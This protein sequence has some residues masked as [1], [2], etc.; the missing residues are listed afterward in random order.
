MTVE[1]LDTPAALHALAPEW[2]ALWRE[3][4]RSAFQSPRWLLPWWDTF[5][6]GAP[7]V[8]VLRE[9]GTLRGLLAAY[10]LPG[11]EP[12]LLPIGAGTTDYLDALGDGAPALLRALLDRAAADGVRACDLTDVPPGSAL[13]GAAPAGWAAVWAEAE[14]CPVL[15][16]GEEPARIRRKLRM[17]RNRADRAGGWTVEA[18]GPEGLDALVALHG[19]R[20]AAEGQAG[21]LADPAVLAFHRRAAPGLLGAGLLRLCLLRLGGEVAA[22]ILALL[23]PGRIEFYLSGYDTA[24]GFVSPGTL[25]LGAM[26]EQATAEGRTEAHFL[27]GQE[28][29]KY[30]WGGQD[31][32][33]ARCSL[34]RGGPSDG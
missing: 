16:L 24:H 33:N 34:R 13:R 20:W 11:A 10:V 4:G 17:S 29:Y 9:A 8:A 28:A 15:R 25:L 14:A 27:R 7:L 19:G 32:M 5:G 6:A 30:A 22:A 3:A 26:L 12:K 23:A 21:V 18:A 31:R 1:V 2:D